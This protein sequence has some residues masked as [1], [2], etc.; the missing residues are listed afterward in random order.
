VYQNFLF[1]N[2]IFFNDGPGGPGKSIGLFSSCSNVVFDHNLW[3]GPGSGA[4]ECFFN[5]SGLTITNNIFVRRDAANGNSGSLFSNCI[6]FNA[7]NNTPWSSNGNSDGGGNVSNQDPLMVDQTSV[8]NGVNNPLLDFTIASGPANNSGSD[9]KDMGLLYDA[10]GSLNW[11]ISRNS[12]L[13][14]IYSMIVTTP[15]VAA[16][17]NVQVTVEA[18]RNN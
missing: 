17:G 1:Q 12:R 16:G 18:R 9:S 14:F 5:C 6:T 15:N 4:K 7:G 3:Y 11:T 2:N 13:P 10:I 8:N